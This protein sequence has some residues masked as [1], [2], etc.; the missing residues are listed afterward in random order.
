[1][2]R[3]AAALLS[4]ALALAEARAASVPERVLEDC[5]AEISLLCAQSKAVV[6]CLQEQR[7]DLTPRCQDALSVKPPQAAQS[8][9]ARAGSPPAAGSAAPPRGVTA[10]PGVGNV[11]FAEG[12]SGPRPELYPQFRD[13]IASEIPE[14]LRKVADLLGQPGY[15]E[16]FPHPLVIKVEY[17]ATEQNGLG[18]LDGDPYGDKGLQV[19]FNMAE[20]EDCR[21][22]PIL[23]S[24]VMHEL[25]HAVLHDLIGGGRMSDVPQWFDEGLAMVAG[26]EPSRSIALDAAYYRYGTRYPKPM[27]CRLDNGGP[28]LASAALITGCYSYYLI[29][30]E[31]I[32]ESSPAALPRVVSDLAAGNAMGEAISAQ[33]GQSWGS[34]EDTVRNRVRSTFKDMPPLS[35]L[36]GRNWWRHLRW[37][38]W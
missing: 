21:S 25:A 35:E 34:F 4:L 32:L 24:V 11:W 6:A 29:A 3:T 1:M 26:G 14:G 23:R 5:S 18:F 37:C 31:Q 15:R 28:G 9:A 13:A 12:Y 20:W 27:A 33:A 7:G 38:R 30:V 8:P 10:A 17:D 36:T 22:R 16:A 19:T 2:R